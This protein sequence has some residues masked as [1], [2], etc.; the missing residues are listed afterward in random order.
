MSNAD[1]CS[2][3][4]FF[5]FNYSLCQCL[6]QHSQSLRPRLGHKACCCVCAEGLPLSL[7]R[8]GWNVPRPQ[9]SEGQSFVNMRKHGFS[10]KCAPPSTGGLGEENSLGHAPG[11]SQGCI[12]QLSE[13]SQGSRRSSA[14]SLSDLR[15]GQLRKRPDQGTGLSGATLGPQGKSLPKE[16]PRVGRSPE[17]CPVL[18]PSW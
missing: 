15:D 7:P 16:H 6:A 14:V 17:E 13:L 11:G 1:I 12:L 9:G 5:V 10:E 3:K 18:T 4:I 2:D 8:S